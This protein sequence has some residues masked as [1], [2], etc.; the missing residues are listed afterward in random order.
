MIFYVLN[1]PIFLSA[2][3]KIR[4]FSLHRQAL[5][6]ASQFFYAIPWKGIATRTLDRHLRGL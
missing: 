5:L 1:K 3:G 6:G 2:T 4:F